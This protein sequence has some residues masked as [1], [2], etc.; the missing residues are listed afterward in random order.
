MAHICEPQYAHLFHNLNSKVKFI[1]VHDL[2]PF[3]FKK[4]LKRNLYLNSLSL[5]YLKFYN[6]VF[7]IS[8]NTKNDILKYTDCPE[9]KIE[10]VMRSVEKYFN[11]NTIDKKL[12]C[13]TYKIPT[14]KKKIL[15][16]GNIFYKNLST[17]LKVL[18][19]LNKDRDDLIFIH[20]GSENEKID[21]LKI[22]HNNLI[23][24]PFVNREELPKIYKICDLLFYPSLYEGFGMPL[25]EA[26]SCGLPIV[27]S[28]NSSIP[29]VVGNAALMSNHDDINFFVKSINKI[30]DDSD[31]KNSLRNKSIIRSNKFDIQKSHSNLIKIYQEE[32]NNHYKKN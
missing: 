29:E 1:T 23:L 21:G 31:F 17:S 3:V 14:D 25:L 6:R 32:I 30:L 8:Q 20:I 7:A 2:I 28:N 12:V 18:N 5:R 27:C 4:K 11:S 26:M 10:V 15:I 9:S 19:F 16:S 22:F 24:I 13:K